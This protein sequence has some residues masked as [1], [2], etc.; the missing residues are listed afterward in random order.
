ME[1]SIGNGV[2]EFIRFAA[3][4]NVQ[5][6]PFSVVLMVTCIV[7]LGILANRLKSN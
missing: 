5:L 7:F 1:Q 4:V 2:I 6:T 3:Q